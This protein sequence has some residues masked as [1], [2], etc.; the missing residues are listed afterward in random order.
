MSL[1][2][3]ETSN[4][5]WRWAVPDDG[6]YEL[7][8]IFMEQID[9]RIKL[10]MNV[11]GAFTGSLGS[12]KTTSAAK[13]AQT[14]FVRFAVNPFTVFNPGQFW[15]AMNV[16]G[17]SWT[18]WDEPNRGLSHR[19]W[20]DELNQAVTEYIQSGTRYR[21][22]HL[23]FAL[24]SFELLDKAVRVVTLF[25]GVQLRQGLSVIYKI[26]PNRF[27]SPPVWKQRICE[28]ECGMP[29]RSWIADYRPK[30]DKF[31][32]TDYPE[33]QQLSETQMKTKTQI[34][35]ERVEKLVRAEP[36]KYRGKLFPDG[37]SWGLNAQ[38]IEALADTTARI[39]SKVRLR[40]EDEF[41]KTVD[42]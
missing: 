40:L 30:R 10:G 12:G 24:P 6:Y 33:L 18:L 20:Y 9:Q 26:E 1:G 5:D 29:S 31:H 27:G 42:S 19:K 28:Y 39:A 36:L 7:D 3:W 25:E 17:D 34:E 22:K 8:P 13:L 41:N 16:P 35:M 38:K 37:K 14:K 11:I 2:R 23:L 4:P 32:E 15:E 21:G